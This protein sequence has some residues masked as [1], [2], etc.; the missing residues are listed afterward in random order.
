MQ[1]LTL[2]LTQV[3]SKA[4]DVIGSL[5]VTIEALSLLA[6]IDK[7]GAGDD[8][9]GDGAEGKPAKARRGSILGGRKKEGVVGAPSTSREVSRVP[10]VNVALHSLTLS[11]LGLALPPSDKEGADGKKKG[12]GGKGAKPERVT[13]VRV[14]VDMLE[15]EKEPLRSAVG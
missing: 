12:G 11:E 8:D 1:E 13:H 14:E 4:A 7:E 10:A 5:T 3:G 6:A 15:T 9:G 2:D